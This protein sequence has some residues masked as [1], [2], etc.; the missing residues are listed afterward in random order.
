MK[1]A[2]QTL[3]AGLLFSTMPALAEPPSID[4]PEAEAVP[5]IEIINGIPVNPKLKKMIEESEK[6]LSVQEMLEM[7]NKVAQEEAEQR[8]ADAAAKDQAWLNGDP[9]GHLEKKMHDLVQNIDGSDTDQQTQQQGD[10]V[11]RKMDALIAMLE[12]AASAASSAAGS[13]GQEPGPGQGPSQ[14][15]GTQPA[16]DSTLDAGPGG[17][18]ALGASGHGNNRFEDLDPA[19][20]DAILRANEE[21]K[22]VPAEFDALLAEYYQRLAAERALTVEEDETDDEADETE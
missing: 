21:S 11:V 1:H 16:D 13:G 20:R 7:A 12:Q 2:T 14:A 5:E 6:K 19:Q 4:L 17:T 22:G 3:L 15:D 10:D 9:L 8:A 18:G